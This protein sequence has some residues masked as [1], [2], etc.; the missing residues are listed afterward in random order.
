MLYPVRGGHNGRSVASGEE[1][2]YGMSRE[3]LRSQRLAPRLDGSAV[4]VARALCGLQAQDANAGV[5]SVG[6]RAVGLTADEVRAAGLV[7]TWAWRGTLHLLAPEDVP[8]VLAL[9]RPMPAA[10][11]RQLG[12]GE[13]VYERAREVLA[14]LGAPVARPELRERLAAAGVDASGQRLPHLVGRAAREGLVCLGLDDAITP[15]GVEPAAREEAL[16]RLA[17]RYLDA[18]GPAEMTDLRTWSGLPAADVKAAWAARPEPGAPLDP[19]E[20]GVVRLLPAFDTYL[21]GYRER[22]VAPE[23]ARR[24]WPG[25]GWIHPVVLVDGRAA[26]TWR[27]DGDVVE[28][29]PFGALPP[30]EA[31]LEHL[32]RFLGRRLRVAPA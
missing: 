10:R 29:E 30:L 9:G 22:A 5:L 1:N 25:G 14:G 19:A 27:R 13:P 11:W 32:G 2:R 15:L 8:W 18:Y 3:R 4:D 24:V 26:G 7:R 23:H 28:I 20:R 16:G 12:L 31:E 6:V 17:A 21:L